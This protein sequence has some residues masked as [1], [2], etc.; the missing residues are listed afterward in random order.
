MPV[1]RVALNSFWINAP[2]PPPGLPHRIV[3]KQ[4]IGHPFSHIKRPPLMD[5]LSMNCLL[6]SVAHKAGNTSLPLMVTAR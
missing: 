3:S 1:L 6:P 5:W 2:F 4:A